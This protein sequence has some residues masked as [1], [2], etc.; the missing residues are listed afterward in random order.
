MSG[1]GSDDDTIL[2]GRNVNDVTDW[3]LN[4][5]TVGRNLRGKV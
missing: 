2:I 3:T 5:I 1:K 4:N